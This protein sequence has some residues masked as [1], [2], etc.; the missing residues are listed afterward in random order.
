MAA[1]AAAVFA[2]PTLAMSSSSCGVF[3]LT[4]M[5]PITL[6]S[7]SIGTPP[8]N[9]PGQRQR[10]DP[11]VAHLI[12][13]DFARSPENSRGSRLPDADFH[14]CDLRVVEAL[15][16]QE[17]SAVIHHNDHDRRTTPFRFAF[18]GSG[19]YLSSLER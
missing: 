8:C 14:T 15:E 16:E 4:P 9:G 18:G 17:M 10:R 6:P 3:P 11:P 19:D 2:A 7:N 12:L 5:A 1:I 13:K